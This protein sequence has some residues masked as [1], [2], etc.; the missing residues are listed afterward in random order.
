MDVVKN[1]IKNKKLL[2]WYDQR[3][4]ISQYRIKQ[5]RWKK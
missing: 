2:K 4:I 5:F 1:N 3:K